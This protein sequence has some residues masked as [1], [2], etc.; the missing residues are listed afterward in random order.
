MTD[1]DPA[2]PMST[3]CEGRRV[4]HLPSLSAFHRTHDERTDMRF[5]RSTAALAATALLAGGMAGLPTAGAHAA[6]AVPEP[7]L[8]NVSFDDGTPTDAAASRT[9]TSFGDPVI[10]GANGSYTG[11]AS[12][13]GGDGLLYPF[14]D[15]YADTLSRTNAVTVHCVVKYNGTLP[16]SGEEGVCSGKEAGGVST[17]FRGSKAGFMI[18]IDGTYAK[19]LSTQD[20][21]P[22]RWYDLTATWDGQTIVLYVDGEES[23][24]TEAPGTLTLPAKEAARNFVL[25]GDANSSGGV[26]FTSAAS[27]ASA[28]V[29]SR[30]LPAGEVAALAAARP[31]PL[32]TGAVAQVASTVPAEGQQL[33]EPVQVDV[34]VDRPD[35]VHGTVTLLLDGSPV[36]QGNTIGSD[37]ADGPHTL[38]AS[39]GDVYGTTVTRTVGFIAQIGEAGG[40]EGDAPAADL[41][42]VD[43]ADGVGADR[44]SGNE[45]TGHGRPF[46]VAPSGLGA[47]AA[48][49]HGDDAL[50]YQFHDAM[51][52]IAEAGTVAVRCV[53]KYNGALPS[54]SE[55]DIC[56]SKE[57]GG[58]AVYTGKEGTAGFMINVGGSYRSV[59][60]SEPLQAGTWYDTVAVWDGSR[61]FL[62]VNGELAG[63]ANAAGAFTQPP[64]ET[65][66]HMVLG[67]DASSNGRTQFYAPATVARADVYSAPLNGMQVRSLHA[68]ALDDLPTASPTALI[69]TT[70]GQG[71]HLDSVVEVSAQIEHSEL[72]DGPV[73]IQVDGAGSALGDT[74]GAG[75]DEGAHTLTVAYSDGYGFAVSADVAFTS[76]SIPE[77]AGADSAV[78]TG[79][80]TLSAAAVNPSGEDVTTDF[81]PQPA[82]TA[83]SSSTGLISQIPTGLDVESAGGGGRARALAA[84]PLKPGDGMTADS[85]RGTV[86]EGVAQMPYQRFDF[87]VS[88]VPEEDRQ[89]VWQGTVDPERAVALH[90]WNVKTGAW[91]QA[92][93][94]RGSSTALTALRAG[95]SA[96]HTDGS[97]VHAL[98][99]GL[100]PFADDLDEPVSD[101]FADDADYDFSMVHFSDT[102]Y[103]SEGSIEHPDNPVEQ[104]QFH[105]A[106]E[107]IINWI[108][109]NRESRR[110]AYVSHTGD[111]VEDYENQDYYESNIAQWG[112]DHLDR[113][114]QV[115]SDIQEKLEDAQIPNSVLPGN[116]DNMHGLDND[117]YFNKYFGPERYEA[118]ALTTGWKASGAEYHAWEEGDNSNNYLLFSAGGLDFV[119]VNLGY[120]V[121][122]DEAAWA[123]SVL[124]Q[125]KDRN[126]ILQTH[127]Y[128]APSTQADGRNGPDSADG[129]L[130]NEQVIEKNPNVFLAIGGHEH[131]VSVN[132]RTDV[133][134]TGNNVVGMLADHQ[135]YEVPASQVGIENPSAASLRLGSSF[136]RLLQ[137]DVAGSKLIVDT[138]SP[139]LETFDAVQYDTKDRYDRRS[140]DFTVP[141]QLE[142]RAT[143]FSTDAVALVGQGSQKLD[144]VTTRSGLTAQIV[145]DGLVPGRVYGWAAHS[146]GV[147]EAEGSG[148]VQYGL[149]TAADAADT[150][151]PVITVPD[152]AITTA[153]GHPVDLAQGVTAVDEQAGDLTDQI[154]TA[155]DVDW[156]TPGEYTATFTVTDPA[157]NQASATRAVVVTAGDDAGGDGDGAGGTSGGAG[158]SDSAGLARTGADVT[159]A[160]LT[161][162]ALLAGGL[163][164]AARRTRRV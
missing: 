18:D 3:T 29:Y 32:P 58:L 155:S 42:S 20:L 12:F 24:R 30:A 79:R 87:D 102:Q 135:A 49:F 52:A 160:A 122:E 138:Y 23:A 53:F 57:S 36:Y 28:Q 44:V 141:I 50:S 162:A 56:S 120:G 80:A 127:A 101:S 9:A 47:G 128:L 124:K 17:Y 109:D 110:I 43:F 88:G 123:D 163:L 146:H 7:D 39:F 91:E 115:A 41:L 84:D 63:Q 144:S 89:I 83:S 70:P 38:T 69:R 116:H 11:V 75:F 96:A 112:A 51:E 25:G 105:A 68:G 85:P 35:L 1:A 95:V 74:I 143:S 103:L 65:A 161:A 154:V 90:L 104:E 137:F 54:S 73:A 37:L 156:E 129:R 59:L 118:Q 151:A 2:D 64:N 145:W 119:V 78:G 60:G 121:D 82:A 4:A 139:L 15:A 97:T 132:V 113:E 114:M 48:T 164:L 55:A 76:T 142:T 98:L 16:T 108:L 45:P 77:G 111:I 66:H 5:L 149:F 140:E 106:Y 34:E 33:T 27:I 21:T 157:G 133:G 19:A 46:V 14:Q 150:A 107:D 6:P 62:Y 117:T 126:A 86:E 125:Y 130:L 26:Q 40:D 134:Q 158:S 71:D 136:L 81:Y 159:R 152:G 67:G 31:S 148:V 92:A 94:S 13:G 93:F 99:V 147:G 72:V 131:G 10:V 61:I 22:G 100:D 153:A 8:L